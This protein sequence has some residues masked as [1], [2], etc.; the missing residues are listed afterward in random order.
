MGVCISEMCSEEE[1]ANIKSPEMDA[2]DILLFTR[3]RDVE[4]IQFVHGL[5]WQGF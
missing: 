4:L 2:S 3:Q 5:P 1:L